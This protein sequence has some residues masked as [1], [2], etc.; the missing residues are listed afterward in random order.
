MQAAYH[1]TVAWIDDEVGRLLAGLRELGQADRTAIVF[2]SDHGHVMGEQ[3]GLGKHTHAP[4]SQQVP[5]IVVHPDLPQDRRD[6]LAEQLDLARTVCGLAGVAP[7]TTA[8][9]HDLFD[10]PPAR[11]VL[12]TIGYGEAPSFALPN[13]GLGRW[14]GDR[15]WPRRSCVRFGRWRFDRSVRIDGQPIGMDHPD[16]D[17]FLTDCV[18][19]PR[20]V[21]NHVADPELAPV[22]R[23][24]STLVDDLGRESVETPPSVVYPTALPGA[25]AG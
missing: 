14:H 19:D 16:A 11:P 4:A 18:L 15:G 5:L 25:H 12:S 13:L 6:D 10:R 20:E 9:G 22:V 7:P 17:P 24:L 2:T 1:G 8:G 23:E 21:V 3:G